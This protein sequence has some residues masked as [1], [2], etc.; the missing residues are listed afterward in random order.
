MTT[1][2]RAAPNAAVKPDRTKRWRE[3]DP[4][5]RSAAVPMPATMRQAHD[6]KRASRAH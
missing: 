4:A 5:F 3:G 1:I 2:M 6:V